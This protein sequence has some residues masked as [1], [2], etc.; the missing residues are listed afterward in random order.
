M[1][2]GLCGK[3][4]DVHANCYKLL[5]GRPS[6]VDRTPPVI[7]PTAIY[8]SRIAIFAYPTCIRPPPLGDPRG[9]IAITFGMEKREWCGY[10]TTKEFQRYVYLFRQNTRWRTDGDT[11]RRYKPRL[12]IALRGKNAVQLCGKCRHAVSFCPPSRSCILSKRINI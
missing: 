8:S 12:W 9:N 3:L 1:R 6:I 10:P 5:H 11:A 7:D 2:G 4:P